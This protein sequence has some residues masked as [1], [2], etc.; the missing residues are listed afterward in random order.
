M[1]LSKD[2]FDWIT[3]NI[4]LHVRKVRFGLLPIYH[5]NELCLYQ[6][7]FLSE[8]I[9]EW[10]RDTSQFMLE[11]Q[12]QINVPLFIFTLRVST[13]MVIIFFLISLWQPGRRDARKVCFGIHGGIMNCTFIHHL[14][15]HQLMMLYT[16]SVMKMPIIREH[17]LALHKCYWHLSNRR[18]FSSSLLCCIT[19]WWFLCPGCTLSS[20]TR[21][22][23]E[24]TPKSIQPATCSCWCMSACLSCLMHVYSLNWTPDRGTPFSGL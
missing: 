18:F 9:D 20:M 19:R 13:W 12:R 10:W 14:Y 15:L 8:E 4:I 24:Q 16:N 2:K 3:R 5:G 17:L 1:I 22:R 6:F 7:V 23:C 21:V 11:D